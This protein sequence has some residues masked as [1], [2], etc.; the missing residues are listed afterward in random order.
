MD[1]ILIFL[2]IFSSLIFFLLAK[3]FFRHFSTALFF[4]AIF[5]ITPWQT[6]SGQFQINQTISLIFTALFFLIVYGGGKLPDFK[7]LVLLFIFLF[8]PSM[9]LS[10]YKF[11]IKNLPFILN[12]QE[13][14]HITLYQN[15]LNPVNATLSRLS[16]NRATFIVKNLEVNF[17]ES[18]DLNHY[19]FAN[20]PLERVGVK[21]TEKF[22][23]GLLTFFII[24]Y[25]SLNFLTYKPIVVWISFVFLLSS[26]FSNRFS[27][28][29][30]LLMIPFLLIMGLGL[31]KIRHEIKI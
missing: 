11:P 17:F 30:V 15:I 26:L 21:E 22:Y 20:H 16:S 31:E 6:Q 19:F 25:F 7:K 12:Q 29:N 9:F 14:A 8:L 4:S 13:I 18:F 5:L 27:E 24:G 1:L 10:I 23:S 28:L 3:K 2:K